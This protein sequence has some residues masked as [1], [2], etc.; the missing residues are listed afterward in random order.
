MAVEEQTPT[1]EGM[2]EVRRENE[3]GNCYNLNRTLRSIEG[4]IKGI[5]EKELSYYYGGMNRDVIKDGVKITL[6]NQ[7]GTVEVEF[8]KSFALVDRKALIDQRLRYNHLREEFSESHGTLTTHKYS[9][10][11]LSGQLEGEEIKAKAP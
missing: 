5:E 2:F 9:M 3:R 1:I 4:V 11:V 7:S 6:E 10:K 8:P